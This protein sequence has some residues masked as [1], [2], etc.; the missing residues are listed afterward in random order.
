MQQQKRVHYTRVQVL[1]WLEE[2][3]P[4]VDWSS[5]KDVLPPIIWRHRW[6]S[7]AERYG[8]PY[9]RH[10]LERL[11]SEKRGPGRANSSEEVL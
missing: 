10:Y 5:L 11:D 3:L 9:S 4:D 8:L 1:Q 7:I 2:N 6:N